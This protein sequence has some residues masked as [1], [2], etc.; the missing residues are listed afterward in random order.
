VVRVGTSKG[1]TISQH[2]CSTSGA[3][4]TGALQKEIKKEKKKEAIISNADKPNS[5][6][7]LPTQ[8]YDQKTNNFITQNHSKPSL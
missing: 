3:L 2:G 5:T 1:S 8:H 6:V 4:A 7:I